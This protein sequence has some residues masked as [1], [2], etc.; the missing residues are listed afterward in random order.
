MS[1]KY[2]PICKARLVISRGNS[3]L[4]LVGSSPDEEDIR[5]GYPFSTSSNNGY[6]DRVTAGKILRKE[7][8]MVGLSIN[9]FRITCLWLHEPNKSEDCWKHGYD[10]VLGDAK[11]KKAI[12]LIGADAVDTFTGYK[13]SEVSGLRVDSSVLS[14]KLIMATVSPGLAMS[15]S[16][17]EVRH[18]IRKWKL[19]LEKEDLI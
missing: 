19:A 16:V 15:R 10:T 14:S 6:F 18:G 13:V 1:E 3:D 12:L 8:E 2:C 5:K 7:L 17:G 9:D 4:L 11:G